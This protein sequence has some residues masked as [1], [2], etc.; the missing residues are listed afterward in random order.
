MKENIRY[1]L[2]IK[3]CIED[4]HSFIDEGRETFF[5][6]KKTQY[7]VIRALQILAESTQRISSDFKAKYPE[8]DWR[9][10]VRFRN[11][12]VHD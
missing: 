2:F 4:I 5:L 8:A 3:E 10:I 11:V 1:I 12:L 6:D 7:A 9:G